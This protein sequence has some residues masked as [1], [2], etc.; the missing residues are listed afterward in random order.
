MPVA[1][2]PADVLCLALYTLAGGRIMRGFMVQTVADRLDVTFDEAEAMAVAA[3][4]A[5]LV[6]H[7]VH[8][9]TLTGEG[10]ARGATLTVPSERAGLVEHQFHTVRLTEAGRQR[11]LPPGNGRDRPTL[12]FRTV[13]R[14]RMPRSNLP[15]A[16]EHERL[17]PGASADPPQRKPASE[18]AGKTTR[19]KAALPGSQNAD[20]HGAKRTRKPRSA[21]T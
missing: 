12:L 20:L 16:R 15:P 13:E 17:N 19:N 3:E 5:G 11:M 2:S 7:Q 6:R 9:V 21:S 4:A 1:R 8:T 18:R 10:Q 14:S